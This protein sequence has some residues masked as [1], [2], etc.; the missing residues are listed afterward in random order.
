M[1]EQVEHDGR[2]IFTVLERL[3]SEADR[4]GIRAVDSYGKPGSVS[5]FLDMVIRHIV[6]RDAEIDGLRAQVDMLRDEVADAKKWAMSE[7]SQRMGLWRSEWISV[8]DRLPPQDERVLYCAEIDGEFPHDPNCGYWLGGR[9]LGEAIVMVRIDPDEK[10]FEP[11]THW[12]HLPDTPA[13]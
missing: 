12:M 10:D 6:A 8:R 11:C 1:A 3:G 7:R 5:G 13:L 4:L 2:H 9:T